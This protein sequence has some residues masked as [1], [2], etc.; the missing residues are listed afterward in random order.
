MLI[1]T[2]MLTHAKFLFAW[3]LFQASCFLLDYHFFINN[4]LNFQ[5]Y[6]KSICRYLQ[7]VQ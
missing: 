3:G 1:I 2:T 5:N 7:E 6:G 4:T